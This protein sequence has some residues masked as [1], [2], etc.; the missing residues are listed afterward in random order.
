MTFHFLQVQVILF[1]SLMTYLESTASQNTVLALFWGQYF[2]L[3][4]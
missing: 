4:R 2:Q 1:L 3:R